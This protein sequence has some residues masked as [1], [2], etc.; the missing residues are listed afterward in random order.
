META[1]AFAPVV[2]APAI[3]I[4]GIKKAR[5]CSDR[6]LQVDVETA[7]EM[8]SY[9]KTKLYKIMSA[10]QL[11][12]I[13]DGASRRIEIKAIEAFLERKRRATSTSVVHR[14]RKEP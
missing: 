8:L 12:Y 11:P 4:A 9:G 1:P 2:D 14:Y 7:C 6:A 10:G 13:K 5:K 3:A